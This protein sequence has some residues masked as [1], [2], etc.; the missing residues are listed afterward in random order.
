MSKDNETF[1]HMMKNLKVTKILKT[2]NEIVLCSCPDIS[3][4]ILLG[5]DLKQV[6][7]FIT[8][9]D[10]RDCFLIMTFG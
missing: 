4:K 8:D 5:K 7:N 6:S 3:M 2:A 1:H 10:T 9:K